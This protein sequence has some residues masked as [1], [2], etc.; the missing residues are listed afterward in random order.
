MS[1][2]V[3]ALKA[4]FV[5]AIR[6][7]SGITG[8]DVLVCYGEPGKYQPN[9]IIAVL[10]VSSTH[11]PATISPNRSREE[12][13]TANVMVSCFRGGDDP[14]GETQQL[15]TDRAWALTNLIVDYVQATDPTIGGT[16]RGLTGEVS[17]DLAE[18]FSPAADGIPAGRV[19]EIAT[20][21]TF[22]ARI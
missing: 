11:S 4:A 3:P 1:S 18:A 2:A 6:N 21:F 19:A 9:D 10:D 20:S 22:Y 7:L 5:T 12:E 13:I 15:V 8:T 16:V 17:H 14:L